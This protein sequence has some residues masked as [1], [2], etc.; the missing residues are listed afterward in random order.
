MI[1]L[2]SIPSQSSSRIGE[3]SNGSGRCDIVG[4]AGGTPSKARTRSEFGGFRRLDLAF[5]LLTTGAHWRDPLRIVNYLLG[6]R[7]IYL[8]TVGGYLSSVKRPACYKQANA[9]AFRQWRSLV[10]GGG[11]EPP[12]FGLC[13]LTHLS[14]RVGLY[15]H[16]HGMLAIQSLRL[17]PPFRGL[18]SVLPYR[19]RDVGFTDFD[20]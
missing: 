8:V 17:P 15:L 7:A 9:T 4:I 10:A 18:G 1:C 13:D 11:F 20:E 12:T 14:M 6:L 5:N 2:A 3:R 19:S 16:P